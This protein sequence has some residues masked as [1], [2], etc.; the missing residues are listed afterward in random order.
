MNLTENRNTK[1]SWP[2]FYRNCL[3]LTT[4]FSCK[5]GSII[6]AFTVTKS[7]SKVNSDTILVN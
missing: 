4:I 5:G 7:K 2:N 1:R 6:Q 3:N